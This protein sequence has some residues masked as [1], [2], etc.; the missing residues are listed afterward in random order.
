MGSF[1]E[2]PSIPHPQ[3]G[4]LTFPSLSSLPYLKQDL[5][6]SP[7]ETP[8]K[9]VFREEAVWNKPVSSPLSLVL[10]EKSHPMT[11]VGTA[12]HLSL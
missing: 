3:Q 1:A 7:S 6:N 9:W 4:L 10:S 5:W 11:A 12:L 8:C 2:Q